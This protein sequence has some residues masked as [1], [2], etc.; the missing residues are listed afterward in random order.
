M[1]FYG[2]FCC[3]VSH[4]SNKPTI[5]IIDWSFLCQWATFKI[6]RGSNNFFLHCISCFTYFLWL[7]VNSCVF[8]CALNYA[9]SI[10]SSCFM[11]ISWIKKNMFLFWLIITSYNVVIHLFAIGLVKDLLRIFL[12]WLW[13]KLKGK[14]KGKVAEKV[15]CRCC[16]SLPQMSLKSSS[17]KCP[18][19]AFPVLQVRRLVSG[20]PVAERWAGR[21]PSSG[22]RRVSRAW[23]S[24]R[25]R[26]NI[27]SSWNQLKKYDQDLSPS[28]RL[29]LIFLEPLSLC[30]FF[31]KSHSVLLST[32]LSSG[33]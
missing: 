31:L 21:N 9:I 12:V 3:S 5:K 32:S 24:W 10:H 25:R 13:A 14:N 6:S 27:W 11:L 20:E 8:Y 4:C 33:W 29:D 1:R 30:V 19:A 15:G 17:V 7:L 2:F 26:R 28:V 18:E 16:Y 22:C 23:P